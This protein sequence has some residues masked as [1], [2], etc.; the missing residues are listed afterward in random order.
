M[1]A[2]SVQRNLPSKM[3]LVVVG[4]EDGYGKQ[5]T[6]PS[7]W[8]LDATTDARRIVAARRL[9]AT[10]GR[11]IRIAIRFRDHGA[12]ATADGS[13]SPGCFSG[14]D[15]IARRRRHDAFPALQSPGGSLD[16]SPPAAT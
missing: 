9:P 1:V 14:P 4:A 8:Q 16:R 11:T 13:P 2:Y 3:T 6:S 7:A 5:R 15:G 12:G 10:V